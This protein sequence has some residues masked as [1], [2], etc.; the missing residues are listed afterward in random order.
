[1]TLRNDYA[2]LS[3]QLEQLDLNKQAGQWARL[4]KQVRAAEAR[5]RQAEQDTQPSPIEPPEYAK[6]QA[7]QVD[8]GEVP[9][10]TAETAADEWQAQLRAIASDLLYWKD[11]LKVLRQARFAYQGLSGDTERVAREWR[12][13]TSG[14]GEPA[15][16]CPLSC[17]GLLPGEAGKRRAQSLYSDQALLYRSGR[18]GHDQEYLGRCWATKPIHNLPLERAAP[19]GKL[20]LAEDLEPAFPVK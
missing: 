15:R 19:L 12:G 6:Q 3:Q 14:S 20:R 18:S 5:L 2:T 13:G 7:T 17:S 11:G 16:P 1:M 4:N 8:T 10:P 9:R